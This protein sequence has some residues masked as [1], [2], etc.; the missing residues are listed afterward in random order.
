[1]NAASLMTLIKPQCILYFKYIQK[2][3]FVFEILLKSILFNTGNDTLALDLTA[4]QLPARMSNKGFPNW[5]ICK[6]FLPYLLRLPHD[7][8]CTQKIRTQFHCNLSAADVV[9]KLINK[10]ERS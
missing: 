4:A 3:Y 6:S 1:M 8:F 5:I 2:K 10:T 9:R 7:L